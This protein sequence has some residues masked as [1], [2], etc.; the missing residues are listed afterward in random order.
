M[1][2]SLPVVE[3]PLLPPLTKA[4]APNPIAVNGTS[5]LTFTL[6][7]PKFSCF[8]RHQFPDVLPAGVQVACSTATAATCGGAPTWAP[9][10]AATTLTFGSPTGATLAGNAIVP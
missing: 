8:K 7:N 10:A 5:T 4:F 2:S 1:M 6:T 3:F 9:A